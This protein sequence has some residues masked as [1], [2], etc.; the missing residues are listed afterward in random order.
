VP[1]CVRLPVVGR[2]E[3]RTNFFIYNIRYFLCLEINVIIKNIQY[4]NNNCLTE[5]IASYSTFQC[6]FFC[7]YQFKLQL[8]GRR[9]LGVVTQL[10]VRVEKFLSFSCLQGKET[11]VGVCHPLCPPVVGHL[12][13]QARKDTEGVLKYI[14]GLF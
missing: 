1:E 8:L 11:R 4:E 13:L 10:G 3:N 12:P 6:V 7:N 5:E 2:V 9:K 14:L